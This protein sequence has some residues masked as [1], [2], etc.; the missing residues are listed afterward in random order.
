MYV[1]NFCFS[2]SNALSSINSVSREK[3]VNTYSNL[4]WGL[5]LGTETFEKVLI[6][7]DRG[8]IML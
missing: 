3:T 8:S 4:N 5:Y 2:S 1:F 7:R 6:N